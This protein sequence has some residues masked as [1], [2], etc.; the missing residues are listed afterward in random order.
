MKY[1]YFFIIILL[2]FL[3][4]CRSYQAKTYDFPKP[5]D[6]TTKPIEY[7]EKKVYNFSQQGIYA[8]NLFDGARLNNFQYLENDLFQAT[9]SPE[10]FPTNPSAYYAFRIWSDSL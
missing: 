2:L 7:Q 4:S 3:N 5:V 9:F 1:Q 6:T 10:N 8:D